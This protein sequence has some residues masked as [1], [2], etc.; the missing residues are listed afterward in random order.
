MVESGV[1]SGMKVL[2]TG[3]TGFIGRE[4]CKRL[5]SEG[6][7][8][9]VLSRNPEKVSMPVPCEVHGWEAQGPIP[10][11]ALQ[12][13][14]AVIHLAGE[15]VGQGRWTAAKKEEILN[16][17]LLGTGFLMQSFL[18][19]NQKPRVIIS[20]SAIGIYGNR[21]E[22]ELTESSPAGEGFLPTVGQAWEKEF[23]QF[24]DRFE[25]LAAIRIGLVLG[26]NGGILQRL[27]PLFQKGLGGPIGFGK[28]WMSWIH[29]DDLISLF[30]FVLKNPGMA[31]PINGC[32][33]NPVRNKEFSKTLGRVL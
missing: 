16:S 15:Q 26:K 2:I 4:L 6:Y 29:L 24:Q 17:R 8:L 7:S 33:P 31:G 22:E 19:L 27:L 20:A 13:I 32:A 11:Q 10:P 14:D 9:V 18:S 3:A 21:G 1:K 12:N 25:R 23:F 28:Q 30:L 5:S